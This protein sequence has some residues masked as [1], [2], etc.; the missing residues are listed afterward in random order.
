MPADIDFGSSRKILG[1]LFCS[2]PLKYTQSAITAMSMN[3]PKLT[4][5]TSSLFLYEHKQREES[6]ESADVR[7]MISHKM[8]MLLIHRKFFFFVS[9]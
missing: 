3:R 6:P 2:L 7:K 4:F 9:R 1:Y 5:F 8:N